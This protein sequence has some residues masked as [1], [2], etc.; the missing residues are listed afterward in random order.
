MVANRDALIKRNLEPDTVWYAFG[1][2]QGI[3]Q[4]NKEKI[5]FKHVIPCNAETIGAWIL[6][7]GTAVYS[8]LFITSKEN[9]QLNLLDIRQV[10]QSPEFTKY[11]ILAGKDMSGGYVGVNST[12]VGNFGI[13]SYLSKAKF[14]GE[15]VI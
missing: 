9:E 6:P 8:G 15:F 5:V 10:I 7:A 11:C 13:D 12:I 2:S 1:R 14:C 3:S 4:I